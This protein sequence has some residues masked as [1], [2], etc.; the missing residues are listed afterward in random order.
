MPR[1][2]HRTRK[3]PRGHPTRSAISA[4]LSRA[5]IHEITSGG[6][7]CST[8]GAHAFSC[9]FD[10]QRQNGPGELTKKRTATVDGY[11]GRAAES[12]PAQ[13]SDDGR[14]IA[15]RTSRKCNP[16]LASAAYGELAL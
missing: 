16:V 8:H 4:A 10:R 15:G 6:E 11:S 2:E 12:F 1:C 5:R 13:P 3:E 14:L 9:L 7:E